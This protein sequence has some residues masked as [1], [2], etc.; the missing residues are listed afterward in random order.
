ML[1]CGRA[2]ARDDVVYLDG[3]FVAARDARVS[4]DDR[5]FLFA[6]AVYEV[7]R[8]RGSKI[9]TE[10]EHV[11]RLRRG[12]AELRIDAGAAVDALPGV[13]RELMRRNALAGD[14]YAYVQ[15]SRGAAAPRAHAFSRGPVRPTVFARV[16]P[17]AW[18][19]AADFERGA[20]AT[21]E[22]DA[23]WARCDIKTTSLLPNV[24][25]NTRAAEA[26]AYEA[27]F[28][29]LVGGELC[30]VEASHSNVFFVLAPDGAAAGGGAPDLVTPPLD[31]IL[32]GV[33]RAL[34][35]ARAPA[36]A[37][38]LRASGVRAVREAHVPV[39]A[40]RDGRV[41]EVLVTASTSFVV[42]I[43]SVDGLPVGD[44][45]VGPVAR[46]LRDA[47]ARWFEEGVA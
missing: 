23:R 4:V 17:Y 8:L 30:V 24:L 20:A 42:A 37:A 18:P 11:A 38:F 13:L 21:L 15:I 43:T 45:T 29:R 41:R 33:T 35:L 3:A 26:G 2:R 25:A 16:R 34:T 32:P 14:A 1:C 9:F 44:G 31:N 39:A 5:A 28:S 10:A 46:A 6:D 7:T 36:D 19:A 27:L 22:P 47:W 40:L 12:L